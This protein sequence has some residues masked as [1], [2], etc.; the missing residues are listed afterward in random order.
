M[1]I[2]LG[3]GGSGGRPRSPAALTL[4]MVAMGP[5]TEAKTKENG[6]RAL[7]VAQDAQQATA[8]VL[9]GFAEQLWQSICDCLA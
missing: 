5:L 2:V 3:G 9:Q 6:A 8:K 4:D 1:R 7:A